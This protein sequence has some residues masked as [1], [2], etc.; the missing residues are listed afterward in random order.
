M[1]WVTKLQQTQ[2]STNHD[3]VIKWKHLRVTGPL[4]GE[5]IGHRWFPSQR[6]VTQ[7][8]VVF[9]DLPLNK[10]LDKQSI[11]RW[12]ETPSRSLW[13]HCIDHVHISWDVLQIGRWNYQTYGYS[14]ASLLWIIAIIRIIWLYWNGAVICKDL[15]QPHRQICREPFHQRFQSSVEIRRKFMFL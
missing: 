9:F 4:W 7:S 8:F 2:Q 5:S 6:P 10:R 1:H 3:D 12:F 14:F 13:L 15:Y 11:R